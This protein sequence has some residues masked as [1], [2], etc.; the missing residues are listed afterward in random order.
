MKRAFAAAA[1]PQPLA[2]PLDWLENNEPQRWRLNG[3][4]VNYDW[5]GAAGASPFSG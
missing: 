5:F 1:M 4:V 3:E 2:E